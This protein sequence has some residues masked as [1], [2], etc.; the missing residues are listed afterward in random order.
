MQ[1]FYVLSFMKSYLG[2]LQIIFNSLYY[3]KYL[4]TAFENEKHVQLVCK[5]M[6]G[7]AKV[8]TVFIRKYALRICNTYY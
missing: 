4:L 5:F 6:F 7:Y 2:M 8:Q 3:R 1:L